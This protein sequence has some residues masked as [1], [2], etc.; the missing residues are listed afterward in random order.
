MLTSINRVIVKPRKSLRSWRVDV[1]LPAFGGTVNINFFVV[2][3]ASGA[4]DH[5]VVSR[6]IRSQ[7]REVIEAK[8]KRC[9]DVEIITIIPV[10][11]INE[12][13]Q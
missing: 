9:S 10:C 2:I 13:C 8:L 5:K 11:Q 6:V 12:M 4:G 7:S 3:R 1:A